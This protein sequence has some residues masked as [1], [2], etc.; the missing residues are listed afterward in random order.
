M[1]RYATF[2][3]GHPILPQGNKFNQQYFIDEEFPDLKPENRIFRRR[4]PFATF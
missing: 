3:V 1:A 4:M 2:D